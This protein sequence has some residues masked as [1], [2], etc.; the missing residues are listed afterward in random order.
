MA[1][2][3]ML[4]AGFPIHFRVFL[5]GFASIAPYSQG[6]VVLFSNLY[7][8]QKCAKNMRITLSQQR[9]GGFRRPRGGARGGSMRKDGGRGRG[10]GE[11]VSAEDLDAEL[12]KYHAEAMQTN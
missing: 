1:F 3:S 9:G 11:N 2:P 8:D 7:V 4:L 12:E 10:R 5:L 6:K